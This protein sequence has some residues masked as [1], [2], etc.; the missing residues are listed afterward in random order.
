MIT[1]HVVFVILSFGYI[2]IRLDDEVAAKH[3]QVSID[4]CLL[5]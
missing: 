4:E 2:F 1:R 3:K 5:H